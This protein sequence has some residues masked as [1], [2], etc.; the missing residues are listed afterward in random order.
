MLFDAQCRH[1]PGE[2]V[3]NVRNIV[4]G[5]GD[6]YPAWRDLTMAE[7]HPTQ[8]TGRT[9]GDL[10]ARQITEALRALD[11][12]HLVITPRANDRRRYDAFQLLSEDS[13]P[14]AV[15]PYTVPDEGV[16][17]SRH[18]FT[19]LWV[20]ALTDTEIATFLALSSLRADF[21]HMHKTHGIFL[22]AEHR[23]TQF[24][25]TRTAWRSTD[26]LHRFRL[27]ERMP[28]SGRNFH[29]GNVGDFANRWANRQVS[30]VLYKINDREL[31][32]PAFPT[33]RQVL[34]VPSAYDNV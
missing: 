2:Q 23:A 27:I 6:H 30:P 8:G 18:F 19:N 33:I 10:R 12:E 31:T 20:F 13:T 11:A 24:H 17:I 4:Q 28:S 21:P 22:T 29:T 3:H 34:S 26:F 9:A 16:G 25:L 1:T 7:T 15:S 32:N 5:T 14:G